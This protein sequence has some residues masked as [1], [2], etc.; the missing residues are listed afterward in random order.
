MSERIL[1]FQGLFYFYTAAET[2]SFKLAAERLFVT[3]AAI[4]QQIRLLEEWLGADLFIRQHRKILLTHEGTILYHQAQK[5]FAHLQEGIRLINQDPAPHQLS[6]STLPS[7]AQHWLVPRI[8]DF[9]AQHPEISLLIEPTN[10]LVNFQDSSVDVCIRYGSGDYKNVR[11]EWLMDEVL[12][13]VCHPIYQ[14]QHKIYQL[15]DLVRAD[16]IEDIWPDMDWGVWLRNLGYDSSKPTLQYNGSQFVL[17]G[18]LAVQG[19]ALV[20]LATV[21]RYIEEGKLVQIGNVALKP[22]FQFYLCAPNGYF[23][24]PKIQA[25]HQWLRSEIT[26]FQQRYPYT[27]EVRDTQFDR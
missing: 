12:Y 24:R 10:D 26:Q 20:K 18:A 16:L 1:P 9:R 6:I 17:E 2:G 19:V 15:D 25:F 11:S 4:S 23:K 7:F 5:G 8:G 13:P 3:P 27:G 22:R 14:Q 21:C